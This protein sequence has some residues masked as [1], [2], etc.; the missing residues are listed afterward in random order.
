MNNNILLAIPLATAPLLLALIVRLALLLTLF[1]ALIVVVVI[2]DAVLQ[3]I[4]LSCLLHDYFMVQKRYLHCLP[5]RSLLPI[6]RRWQLV[7]SR[8]KPVSNTY[9]TSATIVSLDCM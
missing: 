9:L 5:L 6:T 2:V 4:P 3:S 8:C 1:L 7:G